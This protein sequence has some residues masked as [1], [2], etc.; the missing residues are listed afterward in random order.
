M[1]KPKKTKQS[2]IDRAIGWASPQRALQRMQARN[3]LEVMLAYEGARVDRRTA[4]WM[5]GDGSANAE[6]WSGLAQ[7][8]KNSRDLVRNNPFCSRARDALVCDTVGTGIQASAATGNKRADKAIDDLWRRWV[9]ECDITGREDFYGLQALVASCAFE[10]GET[11]VQRIIE[12]GVRGVPLRLR[13]I[14]PDHLDS[15]KN[16]TTEGGGLIVQGVEIDSMGRPV[17]YWMLTG[18]P[19]DPYPMTRDVTSRPV[20]ASEVFH[21]YRQQRPGQARGVPVF[22]PVVI[23]A[24]DLDELS[25]AFIVRKKIEACLAAFVRTPIQ[26]ANPLL[27]LKETADDGT[28]RQWFEPGM[29]ARLRPGEDVTIADPTGTGGFVEQMIFELHAIAAGIGVP[30]MT[31]TGRL[32]DVNYSSYRAGRLD[33]AKL[34]EQFQWRMM[35]PGFCKP[36][37]S[38]F[39]ALAGLKDS[40][41]A[42]KTGTEW[43]PPNAYASVN[44][45]EDAEADLLEMRTLLS[46]PSDVIRRRGYD[47]AKVLEDAKAWQTALDAAEI[48]TDSDPRQMTRAGAPVAPTDA[49]AGDE[50]QPEVMQ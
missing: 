29:V 19:G 44:P 16:T 31:M 35:M 6:T 47:P 15:N 25:E 38:Q 8:R 26:S 22:A 32:N 10:S 18:H 33:Y 48:V 49:S 9:D 14:E 36:A 3:A 24:R 40:A 39:L 2:L 7:L 23:K 13:V 21:I 12:P 46:P 5:A 20:A 42:G 30:F 41:L 27:G 28:T 45:R 4:G 11:L 17:A 50:K 37:R 43:S 1:A 34:V